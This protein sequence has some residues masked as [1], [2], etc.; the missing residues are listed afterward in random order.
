MGPGLGIH[1]ACLLENA[2]STGGWS[3]NYCQ[4]DCL[5]ELKI[6]L[7]SSR[8]T[9]FLRLYKMSPDSLL[10]EHWTHDWKVAS[11]NTG[12]SSGRIF[13]F[14]VNFVCWLLFSVCSTP[15]PVVSRHSVGTYPETNSHST[16]QG[17]FSHSCLSSLS[18]GIKGGIGVSK[19]A[20]HS[21]NMKPKVDW[22]VWAWQQKYKDTPTQTPVHAETEK[23]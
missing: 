14:R 8:S 12:R 2:L 21:K 20:A 17:T 23:Y 3:P 5:S 1:V 10:V 18:P 4:Y 16:C 6:T 7:A 22:S 19:L 11:S 13:F 15:T 9:C